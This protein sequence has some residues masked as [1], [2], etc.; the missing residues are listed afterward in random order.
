MRCFRDWWDMKFDPVS[1][2]SLIHHSWVWRLIRRPSATQLF[3]TLADRILQVWKV[4]TAAIILLLWRDR[5][6]D[7]WMDGWM[8]SRCILAEL[9]I[10]FRRP[11]GYL[12]PFVL[13]FIAGLVSFKLKK[14]ASVLHGS[15]NVAW[16][17]SVIHSKMTT[18][19]L[20]LIKTAHLSNVLLWL[21]WYNQKITHY[22]LHNSYRSLC[23]LCVV[24]RSAS[25]L[26]EQSSIATLRLSYS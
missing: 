20:V 7:G 23:R 1:P 10:L 24:S 12:G 14:G 3:I 17:S 5:N 2:A 15:L 22:S 11:S 18:N 16:I 8:E 4:I 13:C 19:K 25:S 26:E 9:H 21:H 6:F